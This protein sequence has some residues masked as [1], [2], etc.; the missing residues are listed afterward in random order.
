[1][2][3][4]LA[5]RIPLIALV[6]INSVSRSVTG[7]PFDVE[8]A[9]PHVITV[10]G[11]RGNPLE[12]KAGVVFH[13]GHL[14]PYREMDC[15]SFIK[16]TR[17]TPDDNGKSINRTVLFAAVPQVVSP[18][19]YLDVFRVAYAN[20]GEY[21]PSMQ[22]SCVSQ[23]AGYLARRSP[24]HLL[25]DPE[26]IADVLTK[27]SAKGADPIAKGHPIWIVEYA[28]RQ[29]HDGAAYVDII[30]ATK[31]GSGRR[32]GTVSILKEGVWTLFRG[33]TKVANHFLSE[34]T[35]AGDKDKYII[36]RD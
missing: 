6:D 31:G 4:M 19:V 27:Y 24:G 29:S 28:P 12:E 25:K 20:S 26:A 10:I 17:D 11:F 2:K 21:V 30:D 22:L 15:D 36:R 14:G 34:V 9:S 35:S 16:S 23:F 13:D 3:T 5:S 18:D 32:F 1:M 7:K 33:K 8:E